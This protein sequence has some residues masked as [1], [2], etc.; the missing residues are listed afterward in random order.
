MRA[1]ISLVPFL[2]LTAAAGQPARPGAVAQGPAVV[3]HTADVTRGRATL[4]LQLAND[5]VVNITLQ[6]GE[7]RVNGETVGTYEP[8]GKVENEWRAFLDTAGS[9]NSGDAVAAAR[10]LPAGLSGVDAAALKSILT[11]VTTLKAVPPASLATEPTPPTP[12]TTPR[13]RLGRNA[14]PDPQLEPEAPRSAFVGVGASVAG[15]FGAFVAL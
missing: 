15:L 1:N 3:A 7:I 4:E 10:K 11:A 13:V 6:G 5:E 2:L 12:P 14:N 8:G 9:L